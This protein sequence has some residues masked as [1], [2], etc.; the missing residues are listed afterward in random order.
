MVERITGQQVSDKEI[1]YEN[2]ADTLYQRGAQTAEHLTPVTLELGGKS[3]CL[4]DRTA[5]LKLAARRIVFGK[6]L[7]C[8]QTC[9]APDYIYCDPVIKDQLVEEIKKEIRR[10]F[11]GDPLRSTAVQSSTK[12]FFSN[13]ELAEIRRRLGSAAP[14]L[15]EKNAPMVGQRN[16]LR[17]GHAGGNLR[18]RPAGADLGFPGGCCRQN[19]FHGSSPGPLPFHQ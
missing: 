4:V 13:P 1:A 5:N 2:L 11:T 18:P 19:Q 3:P 6:F 16:L 7:N 15:P 14:D 9:V 10:Q 17:S 12:A 8:G